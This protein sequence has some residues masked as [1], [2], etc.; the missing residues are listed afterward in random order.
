MQ[1]EP[2]AAGRRDVLAETGDT[3]MK[4]EEQDVFVSRHGRR[5]KV[6]NVELGELNIEDQATQTATTVK[7][8]NPRF[9]PIRDFHVPRPQMSKKKV[10]IISIALLALIL[11]PL[12]ILEVVTWQYQRAAAALKTDVDRIGKQTALPLQKK[13]ISAE[14]IGKPLAELRSNANGACRGALFDNLANLYP[15]SKTALG[16]CNETKSK[17]NAVIVQLA[18]LQNIQRY[19]ESADAI[20]KPALAASTSPYA[21]LPDQVAAWQQVTSSLRKVNAPNELKTFHASLVQVSQDVAHQW[22]ALNTANNA[23]DKAAF[24]EAQTK[25]GSFYESLRDLS[26]ILIGIQGDVQSELTSSLG[27]LR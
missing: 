15:R 12:A 2:M 21:V 16:H 19:S 20:L 9:K 26:P 24:D 13:T 6:D 1:S 22:S 5:T 25:L 27:N 8:S 10:A 23:Q 11:L 3:F 7:P 17:A 14:A 4:Q 18:T